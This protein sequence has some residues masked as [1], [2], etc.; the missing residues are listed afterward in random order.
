VAQFLVASLEGAILLA[1]V[2]KD[3]AVMEKCVEELERHL[4]LYTTDQTGGAGDDAQETD[5]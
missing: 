5:P 4:T 2:T 3:I 1:K